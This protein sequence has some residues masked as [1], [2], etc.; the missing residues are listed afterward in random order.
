MKV[1][2]DVTL[3]HIDPLSK[4]GLDCLENLRLDHRLCN[5]KRGCTPVDQM[6]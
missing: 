3:D 4:G 2:G 6:D 1:M 5:M